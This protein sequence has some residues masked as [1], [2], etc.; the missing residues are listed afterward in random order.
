ML[1]H[2]V[3]WAFKLPDECSEPIQGGIIAAS[4]VPQHTLERRPFGKFPYLQHRLFDPQLYLAGLYASRSPR[5]IRKLSTYGWFPTPDVP[6]YDSSLHGKQTDWTNT[7]QDELLAAWAGHAVSDREGIRAAAR[8]AVEFQVGLECEAIILPS[9][10]TNT[11]TEGFDRELEWLDAGL[12]VC[13]ELRVHKPVFATI[14]ISDVVLRGGD[15]Q[16]NALLSLITDQVTARPVAGAYIIVEQASEDGYC[17]GDENTLFALLTLVDDFARGANLRA[18][19]NY[20]GTFGAVAA[21]VGAEFWSTGY[22]LG[23]RK[24]RLSEFEIEDE[25]VRFALPRY[26]SLRLAGDVGLQTNLD[27][28]I[29]AG[30]GGKVLFT[31]KASAPLH[32][33][34]NKGRKVA[35]VPTWAHT[36]SNVSSA[37]AHYIDLAAKLGAF[38]HRLGPQEKVEAVHR[39]LTRAV[40]MADELRTAGLSSSRHSEL[41]HQRAWLG[42]YERW[43]ASAGLR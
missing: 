39:W 28:I 3:R 20:V 43:M 14:A 33:A 38:V 9:P 42:A 10:L 23:Q 21:A 12:D 1:Y 35:D 37:A 8:A 32:E 31:T 34:L 26:H 7:Y 29:E 6:P 41:S 16:R 15:P 11:M 5:P 19:V 13:A 22:Y 27:R 40:T 17:C 4:A 36:R 25:D 18:I 24:L 2:N 30:L